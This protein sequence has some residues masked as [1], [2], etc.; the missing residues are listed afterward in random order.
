MFATCITDDG[1]QKLLAGGKLDA[2]NKAADRSM[3]SQVP[4]KK[5][6]M[7]IHAVPKKRLNW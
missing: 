4:G 1:E 2:A 5:V 3:R 7:V 6:D